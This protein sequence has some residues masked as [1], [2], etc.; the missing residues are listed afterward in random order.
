MNFGE[1]ADKVAT[2]IKRPDLLEDCKDAVNDA[3][4]FA[5]VN[6]DFA[7]DLVES[8]VAVDSTLATGS[9]VIST[10]M[11]FFRKV[12][13]L[14]PVG[15]NR[16]LKWRDPERMF[17]VREGAA[18]DVYYRAG[19]SLVYKLSNTVA[20]I[21]YGYYTYPERL[22]AE[23]DTHWMFDQMYSAIFSL[24]CA[25]IWESV[26]NTEEANRFR[27]RGTNMVIAHRRDSMDGVAHS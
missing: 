21:Y 25:D 7:G 13:Y 4:E 8:F 27:L 24:A 23:A 22:D 1:I 20:S 9:I 19:N 18:L 16:Y 15:Y 26:G 12:K 10:T 11:P 6:G 14:R 3:L 5:T 2:R 17:D